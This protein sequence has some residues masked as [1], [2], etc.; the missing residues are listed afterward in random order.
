M[1][2]QSS[3]AAGSGEKL[4]EHTVGQ[5]KTIDQSVQ[6]AEAVVKGLE[7]KSQDITSILN[8]INGIADQTNLLALTEKPL[9]YSPALAASIAA[10]NASRLV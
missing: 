7:T 3:E 4:V 1:K 2:I 6:K 9:P 8:V 5:M 10:F